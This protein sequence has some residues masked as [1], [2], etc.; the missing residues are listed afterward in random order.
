MGGPSRRIDLIAFL[1]TLA[2]GVLL[3]FLGTSP[4]D[5]ASVMIGISSLYTAWRSSEKTKDKK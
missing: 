1:A 3:T 5:L 2:A 4:Q